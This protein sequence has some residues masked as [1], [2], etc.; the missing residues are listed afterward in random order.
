MGSINV[1][2]DGV[3]HEGATNMYFEFETEKKRV[4]IA[5]SPDN[6]YAW[7]VV[8]PVNSNRFGMGKAF[9]SLEK[10][11]ACYKLAEV[12]AC[13]AHVRERLAKR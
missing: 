4:I 1:V 5:V 7:G 8:L 9:W 12:L 11:E 13:F 2:R 10:L 3:V 6:T